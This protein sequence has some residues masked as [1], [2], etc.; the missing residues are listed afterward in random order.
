MD[1]PL[2]PDPPPGM[3]EAIESLLA[4]ERELWEVGIDAPPWYRHES[5]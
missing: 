1:D 4:H 2:P 5:D 3:W